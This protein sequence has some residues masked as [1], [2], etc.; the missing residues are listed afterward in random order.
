MPPDEDPRD[1]MPKKDDPDY[2]AKL[3]VYNAFCFERDV[4]MEIKNIRTDF[5]TLVSA[6]ST[7]YGPDSF[8]YIQK[9]ASDLDIRRKYKITAPEGYTVLDTSLR[10]PSH[11]PYVLGALA[12][13]LKEIRQQISFLPS[14]GRR[15][16]LT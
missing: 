13:Q 9:H 14:L 16:M 12:R 2:A 5:S 8:A 3:A 4:Y 1:T 7:A 11:T 15:R 6:V 10:E